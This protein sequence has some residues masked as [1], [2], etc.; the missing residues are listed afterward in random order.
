MNQKI[1][2]DLEKKGFKEIIKSGG[3]KI[4]YRHV[5]LNDER[6]GFSKDLKKKLKDVNYFIVLINYKTKTVAL[7]PSEE[8][9]S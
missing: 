5:S 1:I 8:N 7:I 9:E 3:F 4:P 2:E 6:L